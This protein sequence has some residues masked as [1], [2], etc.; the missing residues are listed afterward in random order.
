[1]I[2]LPLSRAIKGSR[3]LKYYRWFKWLLH[4]VEV[5][6]TI[7]TL[8]C[9]NY[10]VL[11]CSVSA[12]PCRFPQIWGGVRESQSITLF[13]LHG[14]LPLHLLRPLQGHAGPPRKR[15]WV[16]NTFL[17]GQSIHQSIC[18]QFTPCFCQKSAPVTGLS[19]NQCQPVACQTAKPY[20]KQSSQSHQ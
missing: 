17:Q 2:C 19:I 3:V 16:E 9:K 1:M 13:P 6:E 5:P 12:S 8:K 15:R 18:K 20:T 4:T 7:A 10:S 14:R 11:I